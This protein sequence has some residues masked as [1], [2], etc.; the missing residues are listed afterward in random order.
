MLVVM[1]GILA[2]VMILTPSPVTR[3][4]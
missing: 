4:K 1:A 2:S 3:R